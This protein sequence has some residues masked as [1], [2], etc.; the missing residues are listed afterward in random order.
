MNPYEEI[1]NWKEAGEK[2]AL[3]ANDEGRRECGL[4][5]SV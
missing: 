1:S 2:K 3:K 4:Q 5:W